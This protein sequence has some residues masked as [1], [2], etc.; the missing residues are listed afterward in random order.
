MATKPRLQNPWVEAGEG[1]GARQGRQ[2]QVAG[3]EATSE[4]AGRRGEGGP[5]RRRGG[6]FWA[7]NSSAKARGRRWCVGA[8]ERGPGEGHA[9]SG[10]WEDVLAARMR[11][12]GERGSRQAGG[13]G[14]GS[15]GGGERGPDP[16]AR[17]LP[18][19]PG[20]PSFSRC[21]N[22]CF[23]FTA[24]SRLLLGPGHAACPVRTPGTAFPA[25]HWYLWL[26]CRHRASGGRGRAAPIPGLQGPAG[27]SRQSR[28]RRDRPTLAPAWTWPGSTLPT[29]PPPPLH[30]RSRFH[31][32]S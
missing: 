28:G 31:S 30:A 6:I 13:P 2:G 26:L 16:P 7:G 20:C 11:G 22:P 4:Q 24:L 15:L 1:R 29:P 17:A 19:V 14:G 25:S 10:F 21:V 32:S 3:I 18:P 9:G 8:A 12:R 27:G 5:W 23:S